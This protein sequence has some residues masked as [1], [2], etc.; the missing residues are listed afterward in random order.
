MGFSSNHVYFRLALLIF[1]TSSSIAAQRSVTG[2]VRDGATQKIV[3]CV[4]VLLKDTTDGMLATALTTNEGRYTLSIPAVHVDSVVIMIID[5]RFE[6][7]TTRLHLDTNL[8]TLPDIILKPR[9]IDLPTISVSPEAAYEIRGDTTAYYADGYSRNDDRVISDLLEN[10]PGVE[11]DENGRVKVGGR[12]VEGILI[13]GDDLT[14]DRY[15]TLTES[16]P[17]DIVSRVDVIHNYVDRPL[18]PRRESDAVAINLHLKAKAKR[19]IFGITELLTSERPSRR[20][21]TKGSLMNFSGRRKFIANARAN[22][23][24]QSMRYSEGEEERRARLFDD[25]IR[26]NTPLNNSED[27]LPTFG[28]IINREQAIEFTGLRRLGRYAK[29]TGRILGIH[30][31]QTTGR[32]SVYTFPLL[33]DIEPIRVNVRAVQLP[34][35]LSASLLYDHYRP[36]KVKMQ[37]ATIVRQ[38]KNYRTV[39]GEVTGNERSEELMRGAGL[40]LSQWASLTRLFGDS[41]LLRSSVNL[42][43][44][45]FGQTY[46]IERDSTNFEYP[47]I[48]FASVRQK[49]LGEQIRLSYKSGYER[50]FGPHRMEAKLESTFINEAL[51][52][53]STLEELNGNEPKTIKRVMFNTYL[54]GDYRYQTGKWRFR[55]G[56]GWRLYQGRLVGPTDD[57]AYTGGFTLWRPEYALTFKYRPKIGRNWTLV[58]RES[59]IIPTLTQQD[60][61]VVVTGLNETRRGG[62]IIAA[63]PIR[64][65]ILS[66]SHGQTIDD[67]QFR[68]RLIYQNAS[69]VI[70]NELIIER[71][72]RESRSIT[73]NSQHFLGFDAVA[74]FYIAR[75]SSNLKL[76]MRVEQMAFPTLIN[77]ISRPQ[78]RRRG[79]YP[80]VTLRK[81]SGERFE[82]VSGLAAS[83]VTT[84]LSRKA[85]TRLQWVGV[86]FDAY[87]TP[88]ERFNVM[89]RSHFV[90]VDPSSRYQLY[91]FMDIAARLTPKWTGIELGVRNVFNM[92]TERIM[93]VSELNTIDQRTL[94]L[95]RYVYLSMRFRF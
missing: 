64:G 3:C 59:N 14:G 18:G 11:V 15:R 61:R 34:T 51:T 85:I 1:F 57:A 26:A 75:W 22:T 46:D 80:T 13:E 41:T 78:S 7:F 68:T 45:T 27:L 56:A 66:Y 72:F 10:L 95:P 40:Q 39:Q 84:R 77:G 12:E 19:K 35:T 94:A 25:F 43:W 63:Y 24:G 69:P 55:A 6:Q 79:W 52:L 20:Y 67:I 49:M 54:G 90:W 82:A 38:D 88:S 33:E 53:E 91:P 21:D 28:Q 74:D 44:S 17:S 73:F 71:Q 76:G 60:R 92:Q 65:G 83:W 86:K 8:D 70:G 30:D 89:A 62:D 31:K 48:G 23:I 9:S 93:T 36:N 58:I 2:V 47:S 42:A 16:M 29:F 87:Y 81:L 37:T 50:F 32:R 4:N 5:L